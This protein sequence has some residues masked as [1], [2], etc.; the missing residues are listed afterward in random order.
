MR[1]LEK[2][3]KALQPQRA[4]KR[5]RVGSGKANGFSRGDMH[6]YGA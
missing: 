1:M 2:R 3:F 5:A 4:Q 6:F